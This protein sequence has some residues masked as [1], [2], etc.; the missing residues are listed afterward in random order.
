M[1]S[2]N[3]ILSTEKKVEKEIEKSKQY[4]ENKLQAHI[5]SLNEDYSRFVNEED[6]KF[7]KKIEEEIEKIDAQYHE[8]LKE[9]EKDIEKISYKNYFEQLKEVLLKEV[10][11]K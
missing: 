2:I 8:Q 4:W 9:A 3:N 11:E 6:E 10:V 5:Q 7:R 1:N